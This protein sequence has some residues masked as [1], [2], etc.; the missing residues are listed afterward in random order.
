MSMDVNR[1]L[2]RSNS[3]FLFLIVNLNVNKVGE[4]LR[5]VDDEEAGWLVHLLP[6][7]YFAL[8]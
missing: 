3:V 5:G 8:D 2:D 7:A 6:M 1:T 4:K